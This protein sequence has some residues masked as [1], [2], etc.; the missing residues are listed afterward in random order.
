MQSSKKIG[1]I[2]KVTIVCLAFWFLYQKVFSNESYLEIKHQ[3]LSILDADSFWQFSIVI[4]LMFLNWSIDAIKWR[5]LINKLEKVSFWLALKAVFLGITVSIFTP[6]RIG[7]FGGRVFCLQR[8]DRI[9]AVLLTVLGNLT[10]LITT[11]IFGLLALMYFVY[12]Y[13]LPYL[14]HLEW[15]FFVVL[16]MGFF[17]SILLLYLLFNVSYISKWFVRIKRLKKFHHYSTIFSVYSRRELLMVLALSIMR[18]LVYSF[19]FYLLIRFV[20]IDIGILES[21]C[22]SALTFLSMSIIPTI[23]LTEIGVRGSVALYFFGYLSDN[24]IG[25]MTAAFSLWVINLVVPTIIGIFF[26]YQLKF[27]R[28]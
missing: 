4:A 26:V 9:K 5:F 3:F 22:M 18:Y 21:F 13:S 23:A 15:G 2:L 10:Q 8:A 27:F 1:L 20:Q 7:E 28:S 6:N 19:Q 24:L 17:I 12:H 25:I 11:I 14:S 16:V